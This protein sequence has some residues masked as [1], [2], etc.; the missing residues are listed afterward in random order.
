MKARTFTL[1]AYAPPLPESGI[2]V[3]AH[4]GTFEEVQD[5]LSASMIATKE[6]ILAHPMQTIQR[7]LKA[8]A[9]L[10]KATTV[11]HP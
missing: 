9:K 2:H 8:F 7:D 4:R 1:E 11:W 3:K 6:V 10:Y 5:T